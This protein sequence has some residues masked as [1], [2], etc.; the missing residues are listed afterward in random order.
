M[1][2]PW[3]FRNEKPC[4]MDLCELEV[5]QSHREASGQEPAKGKGCAKGARKEIA[6]VLFVCFLLKEFLACSIG[7]VSF[8]RGTFPILSR[9]PS[10]QETIKNPRKQPVFEKNNG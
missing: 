1:R 9:D 5:S 6:C 2:T 7:F 8:S 4:L 3:S 10:F